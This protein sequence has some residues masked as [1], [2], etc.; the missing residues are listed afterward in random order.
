MKNI[1]FN[2]AVAV[3]SRLILI[4]AGL[5][6]VGLLTRTLG[7]DGYGNYST[8]F[9]Y[10]FLV[11]A[12]ADLG[13][14]A[15]LTREIS[16]DDE[17]ERSIT[18]KIFSLRLVSVVILA[19]L[20]ALTAFFLPYPE[21]VKLGILIASLFTIF[22]SLSQVLTGVFQKHLS[23]HYLS[24]ADLISRLIQVALIVLLV[25]V[26]RESGLLYFVWAAIISEVIR[27]SLVLV[28]AK[29]F[30]RVKLDFDFQY[31]R[32]VLKTALPIAISLVSVLIYFKVDTVL[33]SLMK[34]AYDV[35]VYSAAYKIL[36]TVIFLPAVFMG[37]VFPI[38]SKHSVEN[39]QEFKRIFAKTF[40]IMAIFALPAGVYF[41][42]LSDQ[43]INLI[44]GSQFA[45]SAAVLRIVSLAIVLIFFGNLGG[46]ALVALDLQ[47]KAVWIYLTGAAANLA[48]NIILIPKYTYFAAAWTTVSTEAFITVAMFV[49]IARSAGVR[50]AGQ[51]FYKA[52]PAA[53]LMWLLMVLSGPGLVISSLAALSYF[54]LLFVF[55][56]FNLSDLK[57][58]KDGDIFRN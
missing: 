21:V 25:F 6:T 22:S 57:T 24:L 4:G 26:K 5:L 10:L 33:L 31:W 54:P 56:G 42:T 45:D 27:F 48:G 1:P 19:G 15:V 2:L 28:F 8:I 36:E 37:L 47:K 17:S 52:V 20:G 40:T 55:G 43:V 58:L 53:L 12:L 41:F 29:T 14:Y 11:A 32:K 3:F 34:S 9:S 38:M 46:N 49:L 13:L 16:K 51:V 23:L 18:G 39:R 35:G 50:P 44:G 7:P 30:V